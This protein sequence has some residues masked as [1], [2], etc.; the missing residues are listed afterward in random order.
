MTATSTVF[1][2]LALAAALLV[3]IEAIRHPILWRMAARNAG[4]RPR[5]TATVIA[6][7]MVGTAIISAALV[8]GSS[9][10]SAIRGA[11]FDALGDTDET[12]RTDG[13]F[14]WPEDVALEIADD[15]R[16]AFFDGV[17]PFVLWNVATE[18]PS[19]T[20]EP[21]VSLVGYD[22][23]R[24]REFGDFHLMDGSRISG[25]GLGPGDAIATVELAHA[26]DLKVGDD[27]SIRTTVPVDPLLPTFQLRSGTIQ[28]S[29]DPGLPV[30]PPATQEEDL[31]P[32]EVDRG[33]QSA[34][35]VLVCGNP[36]TATPCPQGTSLSATITSPSGQE[37][38]IDQPFPQTDQ[39]C[40]AG[41][42][43]PEAYWT[44]ITAATGTTLEE[45]TWTVTVTGRAAIQTPYLVVS[46]VLRPVYDLDELAQR[47]AALQEQ[48][49]DLL[50]DQLDLDLFGDQ[51]QRTVTI[52]AIADGGR[53]NLFGLG[54]A[55]FA[56]LPTV[57]TFLEREGEIN[58]LKFS[59]PGSATEGYLQTDEAVLL[60][61]ATLQDARARHPG[62]VVL[63]HL[64]VNPVKQDFLA[65]ADQAGQLMT[66][67]LIFAGSL[68]I[69][70]GLLLIINIFT[71]LAEERRS[72]LG[73]ARAVGLRRRDLVRIFL[74]EGSLYAVA[75]AFA[76]AI[77]GLGLAYS[78][79]ALLNSILVRLESAFPPIPFNIPAGA[80]PV[81]FSAG[82]VLTFATILVASLRQSRLN[83]VRAIRLIDEP[84]N[85]GPR[86]TPYIG[87]PLAIIGLGCTVFGWIMLS[88]Q[89][90]DP[91]LPAVPSLSLLIF[92]PVGVA[93]GIALPL[94][95]RWRR[96]VVDTSA[97]GALA[98]YFIVT[99][100]TIT[101]FPDVR[102]A[103]IVGPIRGVL[104]TLS[105]VLVATY[106]RWGPRTLGRLL[107]RI[108][109]LRA[110]AVPAMSYPQHKRFRTGMTLAMFSIVILSIGFFSIFGA[111]FD[112]PAE[113]Q[114]GGFHIEATTT[115]AVPGLEGHAAFAVEGIASQHR[116]LDEFTFDQDFITVNGENVG[117]FG[118]PGHRVY[119]VD[120]AFIDAQR[121]DLLWSLGDLDDETTYQ[122]LMDEPGTVIVSY[123]YS[124]DERNQDLANEVGD[125]LQLHIGDCSV[126]AGTCPEFTIIGIQ[127]QWHFPGIFL[128]TKLVEDMF[129]QAGSLYLFQ[130]DEPARAKDVAL[131]LERSYRSIGM[132]AE[133]SID[134]VEKEQEGFR[135]ILSAMKLFLG[136]GLIVGV[137]SLG[138]VTS[139]SVLER[140]QE[141]GMLRALGFTARQTRRIFL[142]EVTLIILMGFIIGLL[143]SII[144]TFGLW[145]AVIRELQYPYTI[146]WIEI[147]WL[148]LVSY[149]VAM[150]ATLAPIIKV[151]KV[152]PAEA[153]RY[154]E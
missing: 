84:E 134:E 73:M 112:L 48:A 33:S 83:I 133:S 40:Q 116:L 102:E 58:F 9:A 4:R 41:A 64:E 105:V 91:T 115:L 5:Q 35:I 81:A 104:L 78:L 113:R 11:V 110:V 103:N 57:Q 15:P 149:L 131:D 52:V 88:L 87:W 122:R 138:I 32:F 55:L 119:G 106:W 93:I 44:N 72:E 62:L 65:I 132:N 136:L 71:M 30:L 18:H 86:W 26:L 127:E 82:L 147:G 45:G 98:V 85:V 21:S 148:F 121:F 42:C 8:A 1:V 153:L 69:T 27:I 36:L 145:F 94:R 16:M 137:L 143:C 7:L 95:N 51:K 59:N 28:A 29:L 108:P 77:L 3:V 139:R 129:P 47:A 107:A 2:V 63:D 76:G 6:G 99:M 150:M 151:G 154:I 117:S 66:N 79:I 142:I 114:T 101:S 125:L 118:P 135:Q 46:A 152:A 67:L 89:N 43:P 111:L 12:V 49:A 141:I 61:N 13:F 92:G 120:Q 31:H 24:D 50:G 109:R 14:F 56:P 60:I 70:T 17:A 97:A 130:V 37:S 39:P 20:F 140:R 22:L 144:V 38:R 75:A 96:V 34:T 128:P 124:T 25:S 19:G 126:R 146:P 74:F 90:A 23:Q 54:A 68:T 123:P 53:A 10:G 80:I 100:F